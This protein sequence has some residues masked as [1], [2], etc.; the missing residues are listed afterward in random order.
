MFNM[1]PASCLAVWAGGLASGWLGGWLGGELGLLGWVGCA[2]W[3]SMVASW[4]ASW[5]VQWEID[6]VGGDCVNPIWRDPRRNSVKK[7]VPGVP[8]GGMATHLVTKTSDFGCLGVPVPASTPLDQVPGTWYQ[9]PGTRYQVPGT[10]YQVP[11]CLLYT[12][13]SPRDQRGSRMPSS[14]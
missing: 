3:A 12:S 8:Y 1:V 13:P 6:P 2:G 5:L 14:A 9:V 7:A 11:G 10:R 4:V